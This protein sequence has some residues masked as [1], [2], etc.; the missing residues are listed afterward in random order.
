MISDEVLKQIENCKE[1]KE[2]R[3]ILL[4]APYKRQELV[5]PDSIQKLFNK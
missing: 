1:I 5:I 3:A 4:N 2:L